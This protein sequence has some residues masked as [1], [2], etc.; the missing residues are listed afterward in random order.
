MPLYRATSTEFHPE[1]GYLVPTR[2][3]RNTVRVALA[4]AMFGLIMGAVGAMV[5]LPRIGRDLRLE[6]AITG[7][8]A[9]TVGVAVV[10]PPDVAEP[11]GNVGP[12]LPAAA[13]TGRR[14]AA[15]QDSTAKGAAGEGLAPKG[16]AP[17]GSALIAAGP[18]AAAP[19]GVAPKGGAPSGV[20]PKGSGT[21]KSADAAAASGAD[22][23]RPCK[24]E[25]WPYFDSKC[26]WG[27]PAKDASA[28]A[29]AVVDV[30]P[31]AVN[32]SEQR[33][34]VAATTTKRKV[35]AAPVRRRH[36]EDPD[37]RTA[38][39]SYYGYGNPY[40]RPYGNEPLRSGGYEARRDW[41]FGW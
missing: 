7:E 37:P 24:E 33:S 22:A 39:R 2:K 35:K 12:P 4:A 27:G 13:A 32:P 40:G 8:P 17:K 14:L 1:F 6:Q 26:L 16:V 9:T 15:P 18:I 30:A 21:A 25:T 11:D 3:L 34:A 20:A 23:D 41:G 38:A 5:L 19:K 31:A 10:A 28:P 36:R 29:A